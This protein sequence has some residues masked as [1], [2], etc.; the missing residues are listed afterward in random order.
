[1]YL[2]DS[3]EAKLDAIRAYLKECLRLVNPNRCGTKKESIKL[4]LVP[5]RDAKSVRCKLCGLEFAYGGHVLNVEYETEAGDQMI[6]PVC[7][8]LKACQ[9]R[10][11]AKI[12][13]ALSER[14]T[15]A[16]TVILP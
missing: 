12:K 9:D 6:V 7:M 10:R 3:V 16:E 4:Q 13:A 15:I 1:M 2:P 11:D 8:N 5:V 14:H